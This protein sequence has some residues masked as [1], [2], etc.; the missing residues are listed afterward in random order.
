MYYIKCILLGI[1]LYYVNSVIYY[2]S[3][4]FYILNIKYNTFYIYFN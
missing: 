2:A 4:I 1:Y 3:H